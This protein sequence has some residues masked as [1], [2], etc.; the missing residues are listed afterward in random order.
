MST[1]IVRVLSGT[2]YFSALF[3]RSGFV[4]QNING[5][6]LAYIMLTHG[7]WVIA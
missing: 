4:P 5:L 1:K 2:L 6:S 7:A 3:P